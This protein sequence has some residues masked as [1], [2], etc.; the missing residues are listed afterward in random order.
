MKGIR[1]VL[2]EKFLKVFECTLRQPKTLTDRERVA[3]ELFNQSFF[4]QSVDSRFLLLMSGLEALIEQGERSQAVKD[5]VQSLISATDTMEDL[6]PNEKESLK[7]GIGSLKRESIVQA[8]K[9]MVKERL[10]GRN[11]YDK[12]AEEFFVECYEIRSRLVHGEIP[13]PT[14]E[15]VSAI[16]AQLEVMLSDLL[17]LDLLNV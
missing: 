13:F 10:N 17:S 2:A 8:G 1:G 16:V 5:Y 14:R 7:S 3:L 12:P 11:Y 9:R 15:E 4:Q 6:K